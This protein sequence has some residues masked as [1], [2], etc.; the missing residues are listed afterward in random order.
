MMSPTARELLETAAWR[1]EETLEA[2]TVMRMIN[3]NCA[4]DANPTLHQAIQD[5]AGFW[6]P[7]TVGLQTTV[8]T[9]IHAILD[10]CNYAPPCA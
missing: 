6:K 2:F 8:I 3:E 9:G 10:E 7:V 1:L 4:S 5:R